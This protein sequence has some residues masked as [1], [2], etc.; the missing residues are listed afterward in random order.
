ML[1]VKNVEK[2]HLRFLSAQLPGRASSTLAKRGLSDYGTGIHARPRGRWTRVRHPSSSDTENTLCGLFGAWLWLDSAGPR[3][4]CE[5]INLYNPMLQKYVLK[6]CVVARA[7]TFFG[8]VCVC[9]LC[10][11]STSSRLTRDRVVHICCVRPGSM[12]LP[13]QKTCV[14]RQT[15]SLLRFVYGS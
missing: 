2:S 13:R 5:T 8:K 3:G 11:K 12:P 9:F 6:T 7:F 14:L 4:C 15:M 10:V 1:V